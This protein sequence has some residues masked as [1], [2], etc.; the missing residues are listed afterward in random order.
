[1]IYLRVLIEEFGTSFQRDGKEIT[2]VDIQSTTDQFLSP[3]ASYDP[4]GT[5]SQS[6]NID[7]NSLAYTGTV[8]ED[9]FYSIEYTPETQSNNV[10][11]DTTESSRIFGMS[12]NADSCSIESF[13]DTPSLFFEKVKDS[14]VNLDPRNLNVTFEKAPASCSYLAEEPTSASLLKNSFKIAAENSH[15][16]VMEEVK[17]VDCVSSEQNAAN[18]SSFNKSIRE[19]QNQSEFSEKCEIVKN[20]SHFE[21]ITED[22]DMEVQTF[23]PDCSDNI[24]NPFQISSDSR[25]DTVHVDDEIKEE[26][27]QIEVEEDMNINFNKNEAHELE[28]EIRNPDE[29]EKESLGESNVKCDINKE[30]LAVEIMKGETEEAEFAACCTALE[31]LNL[32][33]AKQPEESTESA[34]ES[35]C[36]SSDELQISK[37][38]SP[39]HSKS[40]N[41]DEAL[42]NEE[43]AKQHEVLNDTQ[44]DGVNTG[45]VCKQT[46]EPPTDNEIAPNQVNTVNKIEDDSNHI[47]QTN[48]DITKSSGVITEEPSVFCQIEERVI[49]TVENDLESKKAL[50]AL[51]QSMSESIDSAESARVTELDSTEQVLNKTI[52]NFKEPVK[53]KVHCRPNIRSLRQKTQVIANPLIVKPVPTDN[54]ISESRVK[55]FKEK[56]LQ[57]KNELDKLQ[58][59]LTEIQ[60]ENEIKDKCILANVLAME[61]NRDVL[62]KYK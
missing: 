1:M 61:A 2:F 50:E 42:S 23:N 7:R 48:T 60:K 36:K 39:D 44:V 47:P 31:N 59:E 62:A 6:E 49:P 16:T 40:N 38:N 45:H 54:V 25:D 24:F 17:I 5:C 20:S 34:V 46:E 22:C 12:S 56:E 35:K 3:N 37:P 15:D 10:T 11:Y 41:S 26:V 30:I 33:S 51:S 53:T 4:L 19:I 18:E 55:E 28:N 8:E 29:D 32:T 27:A 9:L 57:L 21:E 58:V 43:E 52:E 13:S 14:S